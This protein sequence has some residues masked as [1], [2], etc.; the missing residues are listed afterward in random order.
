MG[1]F[2]FF[3]KKSSDLAERVKETPW[4]K[5]IF[6]DINACSTRKYRIEVVGGRNIIFGGRHSNNCSWCKDKRVSPFLLSDYPDDLQAFLDFPKGFSFIGADGKKM[7]NPF[8]HELPWCRIVAYDQG[9][10]FFLAKL[11]NQ[12]FNPFMQ[13]HLGKWDNV[14]LTADRKIY[15]GEKELVNYG[16]PIDGGGLVEGIRCYR[17]GDFGHNMKKIDEAIELLFNLPSHEL[18]NKEKFIRDFIL[19]RCFAE[20]YMTLQAAYHFEY[21]ISSDQDSLYP[22]VAFLAE[23]SVLINNK[24]ESISA[25]SGG[26]EEDRKVFIKYATQAEERFVACFKD[27]YIHFPN[28]EILNDIGIMAFG[29]KF[30]SGSVDSLSERDIVAKWKGFRWK[31]DG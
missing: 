26:T 24:P 15:L 17:H 30:K 18:T 23:L 13:H 7:S 1:L 3:K 19:G 14:I 16:W 31:E 25:I 21:A 6:L 9:T 27:T 22:R 20:K 5:E 11:M 28:E 29:A 12:P 4:S 10:D 8:S 2:S